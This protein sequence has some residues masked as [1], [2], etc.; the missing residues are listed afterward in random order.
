ML[1]CSDA[2]HPITLNSNIRG[3][4]LLGCLL[5]YSCGSCGTSKSTHYGSVAKREAGKVYLHD[6]DHFSKMS[7]LISPDKRKTVGN[8]GGCFTILPRIDCLKVEF[9]D[10]RD[11]EMK[12]KNQESSAMI[13]HRKP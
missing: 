5:C 11:V 6:I 12:N 1:I 3:G 13:R 7:E 4:P 9:G 10:S 2:F 8:G